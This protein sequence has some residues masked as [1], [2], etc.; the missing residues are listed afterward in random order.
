MAAFLIAFLHPSSTEGSGI[1][2]VLLG[3]TTRKLVS[4]Q[5]NVTRAQDAAGS[6][7][8]RSPTMAS[9]NARASVIRLGFKHMSKCA[10]TDIIA[11]LNESKI[12]FRSYGERE[13]LTAARTKQTFVMASVRNPCTYLLSLWAYQA[14]K[15]WAPV[16]NQHAAALGFR[17]WGET[18][19]KPL[20]SDSG[21]FAA[22]SRLTMQGGNHSVMAYRFFET[23]VEQK[24]GLRCHL[25][26][27]FQCARTFDDDAVERGLRRFSE[28][29]HVDCWIFLESL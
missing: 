17:L 5:R 13:G 14:G 6:P 7:A 29:S 3:W 25:D 11:L 20:Q 9:Q 24:D 18:G 23:L 1:S 2:E 12:E 8:N 19:S 10:G 26:Q 15:A 22:W 28:H 4:W 16:Q 21:A 27:F